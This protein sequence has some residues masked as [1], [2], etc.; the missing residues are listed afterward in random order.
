MAPQLKR[1]R[2]DFH[3]PV[4]QGRVLPRFEAQEEVARVLRVEAE[5]VHAALGVGFGIGGEPL[6]CEEE[7]GLV[8]GLWVGEEG[9]AVS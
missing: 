7:V 4:G 1:I 8:N 2:D 6:F 5:G 3:R 9:R